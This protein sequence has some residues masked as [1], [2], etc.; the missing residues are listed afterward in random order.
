LAALSYPALC[1]TECIAIKGVC[2]WGRAMFDAARMLLQLAAVS[3]IVSLAF[4]AAMQCRVPQLTASVRGKSR[5]SLRLAGLALLFPLHVA[6]IDYIDY[7]G[8][9]N[10]N[11]KT[12][13]AAWQASPTAAAS[14]YGPISNWDTSAVVDMSKLC[15]PSS[16]AMQTFNADISGWNTARVANMFSAFENA[17]AFNG[18]IGKWNVATVVTLYSTFRLASAFN[19]NIGIWN[20]ARTTNLTQLFYSARAFNQ[21]I[22]GWN[23]ASVDNLQLTFSGASAF[24]QNISKWNVASVS[25]MSLVCSLTS[26]SIYAG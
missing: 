21:N 24:N 2:K 17:E 15:Y 8:I 1:K 22:G 16:G 3:I 9:D 7:T 20:V 11:I 4:V 23:T 26:H 25:T 19:Q 13:M 14:T 5:R 12:A 6:A 18:D 10:A